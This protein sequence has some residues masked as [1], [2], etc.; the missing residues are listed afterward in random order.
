MITEQEADMLSSKIARAMV[1]ELSKNPQVIGHAVDLAIEKLQ[2]PKVAQS[3]SNVFVG[4]LH[5]KIGASVLG[6]FWVIASLVGLVVTL[7]WNAII[8]WLKG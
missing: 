2:H 4:E 6:A 8:E 5:K 1:T 3:V 7:K